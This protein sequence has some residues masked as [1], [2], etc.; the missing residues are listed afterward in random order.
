MYDAE[1]NS[2]A[3]RDTS[4]DSVWSFSSLESTVLLGLLLR[5]T[6]RTIR[7]RTR[8]LSD[9]SM[10]AEASR[11]TRQPCLSVSG[12]VT[13]DFIQGLNRLLFKAPT[14]PPTGRFGVIPTDTAVTNGTVYAKYCNGR[15]FANSEL[16]WVV[17][18]TRNQKWLSSDSGTMD[19]GRSIFAPTY[20]EHWRF[21][22]EAG[23]L[24]GPAKVSLLW[25]WI[26]GPDRRHGVRIDRQGDLRFVSQFSNVTLFRPYSLLLSYTYG[27]GN[28]SFTTDSANGYMTDANAYG[29]RLDYA[30][31]ANFVIFTSLFHAER[32]SHGYGWGFIRPEYAMSEIPPRFTGA[33]QYVELD[34]FTTGAPSIPDSSLGYEA[35]FG[36]AWKLLEGYTLKGTFGVWQPGKWFNF[37][38]V[39]RSANNWKTPDPGNRYGTDP[40]RRIDP[41]WGMEITMCAEF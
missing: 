12:R 18:I 21:A 10:L 5:A 32:A 37:A 33:V 3:Y 4:H 9:Q 24:F 34:N 13:F 30:L 25:A 23:V 1:D 38:C 17:G 14:G 39:D 22:A 28:N 40:D 15:F 7:L 36:L 26:P 2:D 19:G 20:V 16:A 31:A 29:A 27:G 41:V 8:T 35:D 6:Q 11:T